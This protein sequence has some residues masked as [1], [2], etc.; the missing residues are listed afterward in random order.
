MGILS[1]RTRGR[2]L[3]GLATTA[4]A[5][6]LAGTTTGTAAADSPAGGPA[7]KALE[8]GAAL[9]AAPRSA[10]RSAANGTADAP[11]FPLIAADDLGLV[12][13]YESNG[14][15][16][17]GDDW[18]LDGGWDN[19][20]EATQVDHDRNGASDGWYVRHRDGQLE[21]TGD[22][23]NKMLG[24][25]WNIYTRFLSPGDLGG[26][27]ESDLIAVDKSGVMWVYL[28]HPDGT[29][30]DR[31]R[32]GRGWDQY[33]DLAGRGDLNGDGKADI[34]AKDKSGV[35]WFYKGTGDYKDPFESRVRVGGGWDAYNKLVSVGDMDADGRSDMLARDKSG[36]L[37]F[38]KGNGNATD[39]FDNRSK[40]GRGWDKYVLMF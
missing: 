20:T 11:R 2:V 38:Y 9:Q 17:F 34:V 18:F 29:L 24:G 13:K 39:P 33:T 12:Y 1:G 31:F 5:V 36:V 37:W 23:G 6:A 25:G 40:I 28:A 14:H 27:S 15:G 3:S 8:K 21:Y 10:L 22:A 32:V 30:S 4:I 7:A 19:F 16:G 35:L 26:A